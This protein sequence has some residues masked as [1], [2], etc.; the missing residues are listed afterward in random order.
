[1]LKEYCTSILLPKIYY[2]F[3]FYG[4][5]THIYVYL[6]IYLYSK[7]TEYFVSLLTNVYIKAGHNV[8]VNSEEL[9]GITE[10]LMPMYEGS[11]KAMSL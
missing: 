5:H 4:K 3:I 6:F 2:P 11:H 9:I 7:E 1:M 8:M 10:C